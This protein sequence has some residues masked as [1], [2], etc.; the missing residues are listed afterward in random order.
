MDSIH[1][2]FL[3]YI[4]RNMY[5][6]L[7]H[8]KINDNFVEID[9]TLNWWLK[10]FRLLLTLHIETKQKLK[11]I[12][13]E[14]NKNKNMCSIHCR[15]ITTFSLTEHVSIACFFWNLLTINIFIAKTNIL[16]VIQC[17]KWYRG[18]SF[19]LK[20]Q[21]GYNPY[22]RRF[23]CGCVFV[24]FII[25]NKYGI[26]DFTQHIQFVVVVFVVCLWF[27]ECTFVLLIVID[28]YFSVSDHQP[29]LLWKN[30]LYISINNICFY[31]FNYA[32]GHKIISMIFA[33]EY[34]H[35]PIWSNDAYMQFR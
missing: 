7:Y 12:N 27:T 33:T 22:F 35:S 8:N 9:A 20:W 30:Y 3:C 2:N 11:Q 16:I 4:F 14:K 15:W 34:F 28:N 6:V 13:V 26:F 29:W 32:I 21:T 25:I 10:C 18:G 24:S 5:E 17:S 1:S 31:T 23:W 19:D